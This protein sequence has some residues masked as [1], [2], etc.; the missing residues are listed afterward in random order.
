M[1]R[2]WV[3]GKILFL[4]LTLF[5]VVFLILGDGSLPGA[6][7]PGLSS[8]GDS[9]LFFGEAEEGL[10]LLFA[11]DEGAQACYL[12]KAALDQPR[13]QALS[14][15][16]EGASIQGGQLCFL[17]GTS[18]GFSQQTCLGPDL[19]IYNNEMGGLFFTALPGADRFAAPVGGPLYTAADDGTVAAYPLFEPEPAKSPVAQAEYLGVDSEGWV[20]AYWQGVLCRFRGDAREEYADAPCPARLL[21]AD[22]FVDSAGAVCLLEN[23]QVRQVLSL[24]SPGTSVAFDGEFFV[25]AD[26]SGTVR[27]FGADGAAAGSYTLSASAV[28]AATPGYVLAE[29]SGSLWVYPHHFEEEASPSPEPTPEVSPS[30]P[31]ELSPPPSPGEGPTPD[32]SPSPSVPPE[33]SPPPSP[34]G[35]PTPD[36]SPSV[37]PEPPLSPSPSGDPAPSPPGSAS[38][39]PTPSFGELVELRNDK[40]LY[41][42]AGSTVGDL[43]KLMEPEAVPVYTVDGKA[44]H[45]GRLATGMTVKKYTL[46]VLG[47]CN[48]SGMVDN[49]DVLT[50]QGYLLGEGNFWSTA[51]VLAGDINNDGEIDAG[52]LVLIS[53]KADGLD[54]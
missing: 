51:Q 14:A 29:V 24:H 21:G 27:R 26:A 52:D 46:V 3:V 8:G 23:G 18:S 7:L 22:A 17:T 33:L 44:V 6:A 19:D 30:V 49:R 54:R 10:Y 38:P 31:P 25:V 1:E 15:V 48:G 12:D 2:K 28:L 36:V 5:A 47:D 11:E 9:L 16:P 35:E 32:V 37:S 34:G 53:L 40:W 42:P 43:Q 45:E 39:G 50:A 13:V 4:F 20:Y 41:V